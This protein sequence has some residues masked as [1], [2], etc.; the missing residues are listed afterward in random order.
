METSRT[1][2]IE[3][4]TDFSRK[5]S[6]EKKTDFSR[7]SS[8]DRKVE[9]SRSS[10][11]GKKGELSRSSSLGKKG[12]LCRRTSFS[13]MERKGELSQPVTLSGV[14]INDQKQNSQ[15]YEVDSKWMDGSK[16]FGA[17][18]GNVELTGDVGNGPLKARKSTLRK[19]NAASAEKSIESSFLQRSSTK[20]EMVDSNDSIAVHR[21]STLKKDTLKA[22]LEQQRLELLMN[23]G[24]SINSSTP[25][26]K[27]KLR[28]QVFKEDNSNGFG[29]DSDNPEINDKAK[30]NFEIQE[31]D[32][33]KRTMEIQDYEISDSEI[34]ENDIIQPETHRQE[35][36]RERWTS[37]IRMVIRGLKS[38]IAMSVKPK[39]MEIIGSVNREIIDAPQNLTGISG[40]MKNTTISKTDNQKGI[41]ASFLIIQLK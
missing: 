16:D 33:P 28:E 39:E 11:F 35:L 1:S 13:S 34:Q 18:F 6:I 4:K 9:L 37:A 2:A 32:K 36:Y 19:T 17:S 24:S 23:F 10:S 26:S 30:R 7:K 15:C 22:K 3:K 29:E 14:K 20:K 27:V 38:T 40:I 25:L 12:E 31:N 41:I 8:I 21:N 5:S